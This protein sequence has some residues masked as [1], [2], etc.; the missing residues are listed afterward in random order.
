MGL[1]GDRRRI[2]APEVLDEYRGRQIWIEHENGLV[3]RYAHL[4]AIAPGI[5]VGAS[6]EQGQVIGTVGNSG[7]PESVSNAKGELHLHLELW[8][9]EH[10]VG[11]FLRPIEAREWI[12][13]ILR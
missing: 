3:S 2:H 9:G 7:T 12:E 1:A 5:V 6:V 11:Q 13:G 10:Y 8:A 4:S